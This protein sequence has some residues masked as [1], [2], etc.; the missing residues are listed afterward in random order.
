[1]G[2]FNSSFNLTFASADI[3]LLKAIVNN[4]AQTNL[5][6][7]GY[8]QLIEEDS[9]KQSRELNRQ[10]AR[11]TKLQLK[12]LQ[13]AKLL[14]RIIENLKH[15]DCAGIDLAA[16]ISEKCSFTRSYRLP[17]VVACPEL[18]QLSFELIAGLSLGK[19]K[20]N[21][22]RRPGYIVIRFAGPRGWLNKLK[23]SSVVRYSDDLNQLTLFFLQKVASKC[24]GRLHIAGN[25]AKLYLRLRL[26]TQL[27]IDI[28]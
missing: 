20:L 12:C 8:V 9:G 28:Q 23:T 25:P 17:E 1:M 3:I 18:M 5:A 4:L 16:I 26:S 22:R 11:A 10:L 7:G 21:F 13:Q 19:P 27:T 2:E 6:I 15:E 24:G 14:I